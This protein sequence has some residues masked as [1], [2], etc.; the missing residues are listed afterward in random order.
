MMS[1]SVLGA[2]AFC[3]LDLVCE[4]VLV[5][6][7]LS[8]ICFFAFC[9]FP[10][11]LFDLCRLFPSFCGWSTTSSKRQRR[12]SKENSLGRARFPASRVFRCILRWSKRNEAHECT[13]SPTAAEHLLF[14]VFTLCFQRTS[15]QQRFCRKLKM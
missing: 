9:C 13:C 6:K 4:K 1:V 5:F 10:I 2:F 8:I 3:F 15:T 12:R 11:S 7:S 14:A